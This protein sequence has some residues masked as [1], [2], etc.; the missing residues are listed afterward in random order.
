MSAAVTMW[1]EG[2][3]DIILLTRI[4]CTATAQPR[5]P[6]KRCLLSSN[7]K[8]KS[9][10]A[11]SELQIGRNAIRT[12]PKTLMHDKS[13]NCLKFYNVRCCKQKLRSHC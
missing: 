5:R 9:R 10:L 1:L 11:C 2:V 3:Q 12:P 13:V 8:M 7:V 4:S 6:S